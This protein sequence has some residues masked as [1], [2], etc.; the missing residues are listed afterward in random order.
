MAR[1]LVLVGA[2]HAHLAVL[3][4]G[5]EF[6][7]R[8]HRVTLITPAP[9]FYYSG[10]GP[11]MLSGRYSPPEVRFHVKKMAED[12][13]IAV[14]I[15]SVVQIDANR[16]LIICASGSRVEYDVVSFNVG[17]FVPQTTLAEPHPN[18]FSVKPVENL[19]QARRRLLELPQKEPR[20]LVAGGGPAGFEIACNLAML[21]RVER[22]S[23]QIVLAAGEMLLPRI[24]PRGRRLARRILAER[25]I[26]LRE[27]P[28]V[29]RLE[30]EEAHLDTG[31]VMKHDVVFLAIGIK[32]SDLFRQ[33]GLET[34]PDGGL[35][36]N[37]FLQSTRYSNMF[38]AGDCIYFQ[39]R[40]LDKVGVYAVREAP[41]L[42]RNL[43]AALEGRELLA[44]RPQHNYLL[45]F[46][47]GDGKG[48]LWRKNYAINGRLPFLLKERLDRGFM[49]RYQ[50]SGE[51]DQ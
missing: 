13:K 4:A 26:E 39:P 23:A 1:H 30:R 44:F 24:P 12:R 3:K 40:P 27:G 18:V 36:V 51:R 11:G 16:N 49:R 48:L 15:D 50:V 34:G 5:A 2:G 17:S 8:G 9:Y 10:M 20:I 19:F 41:V 43:L 6:A 37:R 47:L 21:F 29:R 38:G 35:M 32:P 14:L 33:S 25:G 45:I 7:A 28:L 46:N 22:R 42:C 31:E